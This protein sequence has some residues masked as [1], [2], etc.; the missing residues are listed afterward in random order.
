MIK[1]SKERITSRLW[2]LHRNLFIVVLF[3]LIELDSAFKTQPNEKRFAHSAS[4]RV[5]LL[6][7]LPW[8][9]NSKHPIL[10]S[11]WFT[12]PFESKT[13]TRWMRRLPFAP[14]PLLRHS[15]FPSLTLSKAGVGY[16][17]S[18]L[19]DRASFLSFIPSPWW[20]SVTKD[21]FWIRLIHPLPEQ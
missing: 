17:L 15:L 18:V 14:S 1:N 3:S 11:F 16:L 9:R 2:F 13:R 7:S 21:S 8:N 5:A 20:N 4:S 19:A 10:Y 12:Y 6:M